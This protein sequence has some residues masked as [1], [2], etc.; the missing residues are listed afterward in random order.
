MV[1]GERHHTVLADR[2]PAPSILLVVHTDGVAVG[3]DDV[4]VEDRVAGDRAS[5]DFDVVEDDTALDLRA[6][7]DVPVLFTHLASNF[8]TR[9]VRSTA[10]D[11][12]P[13]EGFLDE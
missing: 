13:G 5:A 10:H 2:E 11:C 8:A 12:V 6:G 4:L 9:A 1:L 7:L 3:D